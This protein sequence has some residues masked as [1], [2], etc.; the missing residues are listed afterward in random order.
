LNKTYIIT[1]TVWII[2]SGAVAV[3]AWRLGFGSFVRPGPGFV[4]FLAA[5]VMGGLAIV[6]LFQSI[7][8]RSAAAAERI[9]PHREILRILLMIA[10]LIVYVLFWNSLGFVA[11]TF[12]LLLFLYRVVEPLRWRTV[13]ITTVLTLAATYFLFS[14]LL[15]ARLPIGWLWTY[16][17][18]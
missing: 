12:L 3:E 6:A 18:N 7:L 13:F 16:Y 15:G 1:H 14:T 5:V 8:E 10:A 11:T 17:M 4:P 9:F 2:F